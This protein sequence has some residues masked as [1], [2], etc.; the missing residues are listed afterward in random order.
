[1]A[2]L[3]ACLEHLEAQKDPIIQFNPEVLI[4]DMGVNNLSRSEMMVGETLAHF[5]V[6]LRSILGALPACL[7][8]CVVLLEQDYPNRILGSMVYYAF[9]NHWIDEFH[10]YLR[11]LWRVDLRI[12]FK[13]TLA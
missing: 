2:I 6:I 5:L 1:M 4:I 13:V 10:E 12:S 3:G 7:L 8:T 9:L 11:A